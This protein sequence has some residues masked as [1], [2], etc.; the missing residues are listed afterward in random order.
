MTFGFALVS[1]A[2]AQPTPSGVT[3]YE[4]NKLAAE[5]FYADG[6]YAKAHGIYSKVDVS[7]LSSD[8]ARWVAFRLADTQ[9]RSQAAT[10][11][12]DTTKLDEAR[13]DLDRQIR[14]LTR[15]DQHDRVWAEVQESLGDFSWIRRN[16]MNWGEAWPHYQAALD[17]WAGAPDVE[18]ARQHYLNIVWRATRPPGIER[19][20][21]YFGSWGNYVPLDILDN[22][23]KIAQ[24][25]NDKAH[26]HYLIA[27]TI[28]NQGGDERQRARVPQEFEGAIAFGKGTDW[29]DDAL[30]NY[31]QWMM[32]Q[33]QIVPLA[34]GGWTSEQD[35]VKALDM[36]RR[37]TTEFKK[38][39]TR[40][41]EQAQQEIKNITDPRVDVSVANVFL[42][43]SEI[44]YS[45]NWANVKEIHLVLYAV[46]LN[47]DVQFPEQGHREVDWL[48]TIK[49]GSL[50][51]IKSWSRQT[52]DKGDY[53]PGYDAVRYDGKLKPGAYLLEASG[54][55]KSSRELILV[56]D[57]ALVL[58]SSSKQALAY[59][60]N[61][62]D[63]SPLAG[64][65][66]TLWERWW[67]GNDWRTHS[68]TKDADTNGIAVFDLVHHADNNNVELFA[69]ASREGRQA[70]SLNNG[71]WGNERNETDRWRILCLSPTAPRIGPAETVN[72]KFIARRYDGSVYST[73]AD[74]TILLSH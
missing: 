5:Q 51:Q 55:G 9:W 65:K 63:S 21:Y 72:W 7:Q 3:E 25:D 44:Q 73:P 28:Q 43:D 58:K 50:E 49:T 11:N 13:A 38:G 29:Y 36:F 59:F 48:H 18:L 10:D 16:R 1:S 37:I 66:V 56:S 23:L 17:W 46:E 57:A 24:T 39:E 35:Y 14:D 67:D 45:L 40:Y 26:A 53:K 69:S 19:Q 12:A 42:P 70:F 61:A 15:D 32:S 64:S 20:Y 2:A 68:Q 31:G 6:S 22:A 27:M 74:E 30:Y 41:W 8:E 60:C 47:R 71:Y 62:L 33:G 52:G 4:T 34:N 54:G